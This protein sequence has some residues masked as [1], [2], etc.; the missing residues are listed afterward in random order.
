M[1]KLTIPAEEYMNSGHMA[2]QGCGAGLAMRYALKAL[3]EKTVISIPACCW[4]VIPGV[5]PNSCLNLP[6]VYTAFEVT[7]A[8]ISGIRAALDA[9]G[10]KD[11]NVVGFAGDGGT[12]DIGLQSLSGMVERNT[13]AIYICYDNEAYMNTG[14]Q[15]SSSTPEGTWTT[16]TPVGTTKYWEL[17]KKKN[18]V[19]IM[20][21]H[22]IPYTATAS[23]AYPEDLIRKVK[24]AASI[25]G[26]SYIHIFAPCPTGW[27]SDPSKSV[28]LARKVVT[29][30]IFPL[31]EVENGV[32]KINMKPKKTPIKEYL[33][34]Q[35]RFR[36]LDDEFIE[37]YDKEIEKDWEKLIQK[38][39]FTSEQ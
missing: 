22:N 10:K 35:G 33:M 4:A 2:C 24:K 19:E 11:V 38:E 39:A 8:S 6:L 32:Y 36:H 20:V 9:Q 26:P 16:T 13:N 7:G 29:S 34:M 14:I 5:Y 28:E 31:Y 25:D 18:M 3:G 23:V 12:A 27:K 30:H 17:T 1:T 37:K 21:A 15:R